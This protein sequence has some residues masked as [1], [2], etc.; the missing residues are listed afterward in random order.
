[1]SIVSTKYTPA[2]LREIELPLLRLK[3][4]FERNPYM[5]STTTLSQPQ[6]KNIMKRIFGEVGKDGTMHGGLVHK[7]HSEEAKRVCIEILQSY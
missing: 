6:K 7:Q 2:Q 3:E 5:Y 4:F 1:M